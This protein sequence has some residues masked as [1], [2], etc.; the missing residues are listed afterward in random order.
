MDRK[1]IEEASKEAEDRALEYHP[2]ERAQYIRTTLQQM[3]QWIE[4]DITEDEI[5]KRVPDFVEQYPELFK[6]IIQQQDLTPIHTMLQ[7]L[8]K[9]ATGRLSQHQ[10]SIHIGQRLVDQFVTPQLSG[11]GS[12]SG[13]KK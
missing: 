9:M 10:A 12:G 7:L 1:N 5:R 4:E 13:V 3:N 11:S 8:D 2:G 6:K